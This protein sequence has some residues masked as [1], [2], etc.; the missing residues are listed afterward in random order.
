M[1]TSKYQENHLG[2]NMHLTFVASAFM[3]G[4]LDKISKH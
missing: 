4:Y 3:M 1:I 2:N